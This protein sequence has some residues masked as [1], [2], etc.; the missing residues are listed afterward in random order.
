M[1]EYKIKNKKAQIG[2]TITWV[3]A[4]III[5][6]ILILSIYVASLL[7]NTK[8]TLTYAS[9]G[10]KGDILMEKSLF[11]Y[12]LANETDKEVIYSELKKNDFPIN[13][14]TKLNE[15]KGVLE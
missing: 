7:S 11:A 9:E 5:I 10:R 6:A 4:T 1:S 14:D 13:L 12:F 8:K 3:V 15:I 2:E